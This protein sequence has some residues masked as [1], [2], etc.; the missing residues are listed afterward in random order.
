MFCSTHDI[1]GEMHGGGGE[2]S[3]SLVHVGPGLERVLEDEPDALHDA[4]DE[5]VAHQARHRRDDGHA[6]AGV[7]PFFEAHVRI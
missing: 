6:V 4:L 2:H 1:E 3:Q 7:Q 5:D